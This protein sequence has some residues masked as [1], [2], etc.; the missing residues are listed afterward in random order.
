M[1]PPYDLCI[2]EDI[3]ESTTSTPKAENPE[4]HRVCCVHHLPTLR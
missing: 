1:A 4:T 3:H 2:A